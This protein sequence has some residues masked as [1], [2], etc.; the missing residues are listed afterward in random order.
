MD[1]LDGDYNGGSRL[2]SSSYRR[3]LGVTCKELMARGVSFKVPN[4]PSITAWVDFTEFGL[5]EP[6]EAGGLTVITTRPTIPIW[7]FITVSIAL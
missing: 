4:G 1:S 6:Q 2:A 3:P 7:S 5:A